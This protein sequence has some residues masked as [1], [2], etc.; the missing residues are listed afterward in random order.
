MYEHAVTACPDNEEYLSHLFMAHVRL[1]N[2]KRQQQIAVK[3][4]KVKP[5]NN[6][7]YYWSVMSLVLQVCIV[8]YNVIRII[9]PRNYS[10]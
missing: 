1:H 5:D 9:K 8:F 10:L 6:P 7:Y 2:Y 3:L 4:H